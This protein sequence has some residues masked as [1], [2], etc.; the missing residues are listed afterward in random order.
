MTLSSDW[1]HR[2]FSQ[3]EL[4][5]FEVN[6]EKIVYN[7]ENGIVLNLGLSNN[8]CID[9][10]RNWGMATNGDLD[11]QEYVLDFFDSFVEYLEG[12]LLDEG[13]NFTEE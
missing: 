7:S 13:I 9:I 3:A 8:T 4:E 1:T 10:V 5:E 2:L 11:A 12:Y 6:S